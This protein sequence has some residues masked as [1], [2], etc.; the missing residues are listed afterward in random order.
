MQIT[1]TWHIES[2]FYKNTDLSHKEES[3]QPSSKFKEEYLK[4][5]QP[6]NFIRLKSFKYIDSAK[7]VELSGVT[8]ELSG[9]TQPKVYMVELKWHSFIVVLFTCNVVNIYIIIC[10]I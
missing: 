3:V 9:V 1:Q 10:Y 6:N 8:Q 7:S 5:E 2:K 4:C